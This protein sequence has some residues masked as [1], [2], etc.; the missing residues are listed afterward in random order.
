MQKRTGAPL[1]RIEIETEADR[2]FTRF[3]Y[4]SIAYAG[5]IAA[6]DCLT[7]RGESNDRRTR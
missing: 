6:G 7:N 3:G 4:L 5:D 1:S 2:L